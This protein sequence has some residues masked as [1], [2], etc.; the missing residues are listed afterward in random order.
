MLRPESLARL[1]FSSARSYD[2]PL[3]AVVLAVALA[4]CATGG[5]GGLPD[6]PVVKDYE[7]K[8]WVAPLKSGLRVIVKEDHSAP[9]V[10]IVSVYGV[11]ATADPKGV[12]GLAHFVEHLAFR[13]RPGGG[14]QYWDV[15]KRMGAF[16]NATTSHDLTSYYTVAHKSNLH[17]M[18]QLEAW[19]LARTVEGVTPEVFK[20]EREVVRNELRQRWESTVGNK[21]FDLIF[22]S[23]FPDGHPLR[24]PVGGTHDSLTRTQL[25]DA[26][27][28]VKDHYTP[29]NCTIVI[30][31]DFDT[32]EVKKMLGMWPVEV[33][34]GPE[35]PEGAAVNPRPRV[36]ERPTPPLPTTVNRQLQR[37]KGPISQ[38]ELVLAWALPPGWRG[39]DSLAQFAASR[40]NLALSEGLADSKEDDDIL[41]AGAG[42]SEMGFA[43]IMT[44]SAVLKPGADPE[45][46][47]RRLEDVL[48]NAWTTELG[49]L[50]TESVRWGA[51]TDTL[52]LSA[53]PVRSAEDLAEYAATTGKTSRFNDKLEELAAVKSEQVSDFAFKWLTRE[54]AAATFF[55]PESTEN[56]RL[57]G[58]GSGQVGGDDR[59]SH[60]IGGEIG[61][62]GEY[63]S[64]QILKTVMPPGLPT[65]PRTKLSNGLEMFVIKSMGAPVVQ[66]TLS[67]RGGNA[68]TKPLNA[69][70]LSINISRSRCRDHG[71]LD[72]VGGSIGT[73]TGLVTSGTSV[74]VLSGNLANG[75]AVLS[76]T[77]RCREADE[78]AF[79]HLSR[80]L[81]RRQKDYE[82]NSKQPEYVA[83]KRLFT[84]LYPNHPFGEARYA[85]PMALKDFRR[86]DAQAFVQSHFR[87]DNGTLVI[88][89]D[90][91]E[92]QVKKD[93][94]QYLGLWPTGGGVAAMDAPPPPAGPQARRVFLIDRPKATQA[95][96][97]VGCRLVDAKPEILPAFEVLEQVADEQA[98]K[99]RQQW[100]AT[101]G[102]A[103]SVA[104]MPGGAS[105]M[106]FSGLVENAQTG[107]AVGAL[108]D[109]VA[110]IGSGKINQ[111]L[112]E[113]KRWDAGREFMRRFAMPSARASAIVDLMT[114]R[115]P[116]DTW[117]KYPERLA[118]TTPA[119]VKELLAPCVGKEIVAI[120]GDAAVLRPQLEKEGLKLESK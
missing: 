67:L 50:Q 37:L 89:G 17:Q 66:M 102:V 13:S 103:A 88:Y 78:E 34:F 16:F 73:G 91:D 47:R 110:E 60:T 76:D 26:Q 56:P 43:S 23:L 109:I 71:D 39:S 44:M 25:T 7:A 30:A 96:V 41:G 120:V 52:L 74:S 22:S 72:A 86:E 106:S 116:L 79:L 53:N 107:K 63:G 29:D 35:G 20:T 62:G 118:A 24:R 51:A 8:E 32:E 92:E 5:A 27:K 38:S 64:A 113:T 46:A 80:V 12:E 69:A 117:E 111:Q 104:N 99:L 112:F 65:V 57:V 3:P 81:E 115:W 9:Q 36:A 59:N 19:R 119:A 42:V 70:S 4:A 94:Q 95:M 100:G 21:M 58:G 6:S 90:V 101:Y 61:G 108:L 68:T 1:R 77:V 14:P 105:D 10:T 82:Q 11:G 55:E 54:R 48:V 75:L 28:F 45:K 40:L 93:A 83:G 2:R 87:P 98:G 114:R 31:G 85:E 84:S 33:L 49:R 15:L 97:N 18:M